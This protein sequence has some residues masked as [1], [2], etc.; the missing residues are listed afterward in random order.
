MLHPNSYSLRRIAAEP[1]GD[2][3]P[4]RETKEH[5]R[6]CEDCSREVALFRDLADTANAIGRATPFQALD[7][8]P[9]DDQIRS[10]ASGL[11]SV[12]NSDALLT[13]AS[14]CDRCGRVLL[15]AV[16]DFN[17]A[18]SEEELAFVDALPRPASRAKSSASERARR[19]A[20]TWINIRW[21]PAYLAAMLIFSTA[22]W[23]SYLKW[24]SWRAEALVAQAYAADRTIPLRFQGAEYGAFTPTRADRQSRPHALV[25]AEDLIG[26]SISGGTRVPQVQQAWARLL[27]LEWRYEE[28]LSIL[29]P[30]GAD[31]N[32]DPSVIIDLASARFERGKRFGDYRDCAGAVELLSRVLTKDETNGIAL[33]NRALIYEELQM[34]QEARRDWQTYLAGDQNSPWSV[35]ARQHLEKVRELIERNKGLVEPKPARFLAAAERDIRVE[36]YLPIA[37][38]RWLPRTCTPDSVERSA[39]R[40]LADLMESANGD[41]WLNDLLDGS[42]SESAC[43]AGLALAQALEIGSKGDAAQALTYAR[44]AAQR[45]TAIHNNAG[46][47]RAELE[48][49]YEQT[50]G[51]RATSCRGSEPALF[52]LQVSRYPWIAIDAMIE[53]ALCKAAQGRL[54]QARR[55]FT[56][57]NNQ[58]SVYHFDGLAL[59][60]LGLAETVDIMSGNDQTG[61]TEAL[62]G[63]VQF[64]SGSHAAIR[65]YQFYSDLTLWAETAHYPS[66]AFAL[67]RES[68][69][70]ADDQPNLMTRALAHYLLAVDAIG[71]GQPKEARTHFLIADQ[72]FHVFPENV[73]GIYRLYCSMNRALLDANSANSIAELEHIAPSVQRYGQS[74][75]L[76]RYYRQLARAYVDRR[77]LPLAEITFASA[78]RYAREGV[79]SFANDRERAAWNGDVDD[80]YRGLTA[81]RLELHGDSTGAL[82]LWQEHRRIS[83]AHEVHRHSPKAHIDTSDVLT[84]TTLQLPNRIAYWASR[85]GTTIFHW[86]P[87]SRETAR[88]MASSFTNACANPASKLEDI[89]HIGSRISESLL[90]PAGS[91]VKA[92]ALIAVDID[93]PLRCVPVQALPDGTSHYIGE[94]VPVARVAGSVG[95]DALQAVLISRAV[96]II[97]PLVRGA[98]SGRFVPVGRGEAPSIAA[99]FKDVSS[100]EGPSATLLNIEHR[101]SGVD[102]FHFIGHAE[103]LAYG[104]GLVV[105]PGTDEGQYDVLGASEAGLWLNRCQLA[106]L[107]ACSTG[108]GDPNGL[109]EPDDLAMAFLRAGPHTVIAS[110]WDVRSESTSALMTAF[111]SR[112][113]GEQP[114]CAALQQ[115]SVLLRKNPDYRHPYFWSSFSCYVAPL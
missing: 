49:A 9:A 40:R 8:C 46:E 103:R 78:L 85:G 62:R 7:E 93:G 65:G 38:T 5:L 71:A 104:A 27:L 79:A 30:L 110:N 66:L 74:P 76:L 14:R 68:V 113:S 10:V 61:W 84:V 59:R 33:F 6:H 53:E 101:S 80:V 77:N 51:E 82:E 48:I 111:Y 44:T 108:S 12:E 87:T 36:L 26:G 58:A 11:S 97:N 37:L 64:W 43:A 52:R 89:Q 73:S 91:L 70:L 92:A 29:S 39:L 90:A 50:R 20:S 45:Y 75:M 21:L 23:F 109:D 107:A 1:S 41:S 13:H 57:A 72:I 102:L 54:G 95:P 63:L 112:I 34:P 24:Q 100:V 105:A 56:I 42:D 31:E 2:S 18:A 15:Q 55:G 83:A 16:E 98:A 81:I 114:P 22:I 115:A 47:Q 60:A 96:L 17:R 86:V 88:E 3:H 99:T 106:V 25:R 69:S 4:D 32:A 19:W 35:E 67:A 28:A 94:T